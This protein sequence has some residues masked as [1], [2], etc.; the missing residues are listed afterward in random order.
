MKAFFKVQDVA[1]VHALAQ[2]LAPLHAEEVPLEL[3]L[4]RALARPLAA[5]SDLPGF[6]RATMDGYAVRAMDTFGAGEISPGYLDIVGEVRMGQAPAFSVGP[7]Q[8]ARIGTGGMLPAGSDAVVMVEHTRL[9]DDT[10][11]EVAAAVAPGGNTLGPTD[12]AAQGQ[13]LLPQGQCLR[14]QDLGLLAALGQEMVSVSRRPRVGIV[15]TGDEVVPVSA[16]PAP[17]QVRDVNTY[18]LAAQIARAGGEPLPL[19]LVADNAQALQEA[20]ARSLESCDLTLLSGGSSVGVRDFTSEVFLSFPGAELL[21]HGVAV[22]P[23]KP[24]LWVR[25]PSGHLLG[26]PGQVASC[27]V[28]FYLLVEPILERLQGRLAL[29]FAHFARLPAVLTRNIPSAPGREEY[30][31]VSLNQEGGQWLAQPLFGKS[32]LLTTMI[33][34]QGLVRVPKDC[35]GLDAAEVV[36]VLLFPN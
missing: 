26:L 8:C 9:L 4:G 12:D 32:G 24:F 23:G 36:E 7:G 27:L 35:E 15:S 1:T 10:N 28:S 25:T 13:E 22:S 33:Q 2:E 31:R 20:T 3:A 17:G 5:P 6:T 34:G 18:T 30:L 29:P 19:G 16:N 14:P 11:V 21:V